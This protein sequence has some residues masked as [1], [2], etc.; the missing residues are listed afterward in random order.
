MSFTPFS[1]TICHHQII[2]NQSSDLDSDLGVVQKLVSFSSHA[3]PDPGVDTSIHL[4]AL[5][6][7]AVYNRYV[8]TNRGRCRRAC[9][10]PFRPL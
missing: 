1:T 3:C 4:G 8:I 6:S 5:G 9:R 10:L 7:I 2:T